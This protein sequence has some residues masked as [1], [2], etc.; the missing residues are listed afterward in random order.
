LEEIIALIFTREQEESM[1]EDIVPGDLVAKIVPFFVKNRNNFLRMM[2]FLR[3][4]EDTGK[5]SSRQ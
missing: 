5:E 1:N 3:I 2:K 4:T